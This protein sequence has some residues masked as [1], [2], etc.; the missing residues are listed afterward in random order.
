MFTALIQP[1]NQKNQ[2][3]SKIERQGNEVQ[4]R[5]QKTWMAKHQAKN[6]EK[7]AVFHILTR[8]NKVEGLWVTFID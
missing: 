7:V 1:P 8:C 6:L 5:K 3:V 2:L 4:V